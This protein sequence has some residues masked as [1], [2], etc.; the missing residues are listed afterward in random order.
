MHNLSGR[1]HCEFF[2]G[3]IEKIK[4]VPAHV[5][6][7]K[8]KAWLGVRKQLEYVYGDTDAATV[9]HIDDKVA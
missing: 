3:M 2:S 4:G 6:I 9:L 5:S 1:T 8:A 7:D